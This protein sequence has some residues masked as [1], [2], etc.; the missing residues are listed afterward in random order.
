MSLDLV[1]KKIVARNI[2]SCKNIDVFLKHI[3]RALPYRGISDSKFY[4]CEVES[5]RFFVKLCPYNKTHPEI[6]GQT[7]SIP[8]AQEASYALLPPPDAELKILE[9]FRTKLIETGITPCILELIHHKICPVNAGLIPS[10]KQCDLLQ[11][12]AHEATNIEEDISLNFCAWR[13]KIFS[14]L[15]HNRIVFMVLEKCNMVLS[16]FIKSTIDTPIHVAIMRSIL[17]MLVYT[18]FAITTIY[19]KFHHRDLHVDNVML[20]FDDSYIFNMNKPQYLTFIIIDTANERV[21]Y[22]V[23]Y[24]G[25]IPKIIDFGFSSIPEEN[26]MSAVVADKS[27]MYERADNDLIFLFYWIHYAIEK[28]SPEVDKMLFA[29]DPTGSFVR[30][31]TEHIRR[32]EGIPTYKMMLNNPI[33]SQY[34]HSVPLTQT[35]HTYELSI[36]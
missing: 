27:L 18:L 3:I 30:F 23:P 6:Y 36:E 33:F 28:S 2:L 7:Q 34:K 1:S 15:A 10:D 35:Y 32:T 14:G 20:K 31:Q 24:F 11:G 17:F 26:I 8:T 25:I 5:I 19:P 22:N 16:Q 9:I 21:V 13:D 12:S 4:L 29:L